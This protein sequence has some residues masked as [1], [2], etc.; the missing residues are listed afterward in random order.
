MNRLATIEHDGRA[1]RFDPDARAFEA[2]A[3]SGDQTFLLDPLEAGTIADAL[4]ETT[5]RWS[6]DR[7]QRLAVREIGNGRDVLHIYAV[8]RKSIG[9]RVWNGHVPMTEYKRWLDHICT[10]DL[11]VVAGIPRGLVGCEVEI[12]N[13]R[14]QQRP[15]GARLSR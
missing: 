1:T 14:Q 3:V 8:R 13:R 10:V 12:H 5:A 15:E 7:G 4:A 9:N 11:N 2:F 6:W